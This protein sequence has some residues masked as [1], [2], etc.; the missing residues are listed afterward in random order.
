MNVAVF[1]NVAIDAFVHHSPIHI[2]LTALI[3]AVAQGNVTTQGVVKVDSDAY[4]LCSRRNVGFVIVDF[5][6]V[7]ITYPRQVDLGRYWWIQHDIEVVAI[8]LSSRWLKA[9]SLCVERLPIPFPTLELFFIHYVSI[10]TAAWGY[11]DT[12]L[13]IA[14]DAIISEIVAQGVFHGRGIKTIY[15]G[16]SL[17]ISCSHKWKSRYDLG[18]KLHIGPCTRYILCIGKPKFD[19]YEP[20]T[21]ITSNFCFVAFLHTSVGDIKILPNLRVDVLHDPE[22]E[23]QGQQGQELPAIFHCPHAQLF[24]HFLKIFKFVDFH[25]KIGGYLDTVKAKMNKLLK[26]F[27]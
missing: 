8:K 18:V 14:T 22:G 17:R 4:H 24:S 15:I 26:F 20:V 27:D 9:K 10:F 7:V 1:D 12:S 19:T 3:E 23:Q 5:D 13:D 21:E 25:G 11:I 16:E 6:G 2:A